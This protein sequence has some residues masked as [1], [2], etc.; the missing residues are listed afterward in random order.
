MTTFHIGVLFIFMVLA[1]CAP[2]C[3]GEAP[4]STASFGGSRFVVEPE[5]IDEEPLPERVSYDQHVVPILEGYGCVA[6]HGGQGGLEVVPL[7]ALLRTGLSAPVV[8]PCDA[9]GSVLYRRMAGEGADGPAMPPLEGLV[10]STGEPFVPER[11]GPVTPRDLAIVRR[12]IEGGGDPSA[13]RERPDA[14]EDG[15][16]EED[17]VGDVAQ[18][19]DMPDGDARDVTPDVAR[20]TAADGEG[21][22]GEPDVADL[23]DVSPDVPEPPQGLSFREDILPLLLRNRC[24]RCHGGDG[25]YT[26]NNAEDAVMTG[27]HGPA[28]IPCDPENSALIQKVL[29]N[30]PFGDRMPIRSNSA[31]MPEAD[32]EI[33]RQ[34]IR[35][36]A[37]NVPDPTYC[38][39]N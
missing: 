10:D 18:D 36:G 9:E 39:G 32:V 11:V 13:C 15:G 27:E 34:W 28:V 24:L 38:D 30:P 35:E 19:G 21:D 31:W 23:D 7:S 22:T 5:G 25:G 29:P 4:G 6:C 26:C 8:V 17:A 37:R 16:G 12:W 14:G 3:T 33:L 1:L 20:D 2:G